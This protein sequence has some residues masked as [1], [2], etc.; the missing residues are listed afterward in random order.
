MYAV[1]TY[2]ANYFTSEPRLRCKTVSAENLDE[3]IAIANQEFRI[4]APCDLPRIAGIKKGMDVTTWSEVQMFRFAGDAR[5]YRKCIETPRKWVRNDSKGLFILAPKNSKTI[6]AL[7][8]M[9]ARVMPHSSTHVRIVVNPH[10]WSDAEMLPRKFQA[11]I[12]K[13]A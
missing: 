9:P 8:A 3:A 6:K 4:E 1:I 5:E 2:I 7:A 13:Y 11:D 10:E 12:L